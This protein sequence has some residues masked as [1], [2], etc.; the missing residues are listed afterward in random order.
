M[1]EAGQSWAR[2]T[3]RKIAKTHVVIL[4]VWVMSHL[5]TK[6]LITQVSIIFLIDSSPGDTETPVRIQRVYNCTTLLSLVTLNNLNL[7]NRWWVQTVQPKIK[8]WWVIQ[9]V[10]CK[11]THVTG[12]RGVSLS[13]AHLPCGASSYESQHHSR[14][15]GRSHGGQ[16]VCTLL[17]LLWKPLT[18]DRVMWHP[19]IPCDILENSNSNWA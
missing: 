10:I 2:I 14:Q 11:E 4:Q 5:Y 19:M 15:R 16:I 1:S 9:N 6:K 13:V 17:S 8:T 3:N 18:I 12:K 7:V